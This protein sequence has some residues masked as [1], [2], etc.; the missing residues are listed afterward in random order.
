MPTEEF[1]QE[2]AMVNEQTLDDLPEAF[3]LT[4]TSPMISRC[5]EL[6]PERL[7]VQLER[8]D[9][10]ND[11]EK[12]PLDTP[13]EISKD[14]EMALKAIHGIRDCSVG[15]KE[16]R[17]I[18]K[19]ALVGSLGFSKELSTHGIVLKCVKGCGYQHVFTSYKTIRSSFHQHFK[20]MH[21]DDD[22]W[23][24]YCSACD[25]YI[26]DPDDPESVEE[27]L[28]MKSELEHIIKHHTRSDVTD[29]SINNN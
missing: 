25:S 5:E 12:L 16:M 11:N 10:L 15:V 22:S 9:Q 8:Y 17:Y 29:P 18:Y 28:T 26:H 20:Q 24:G 3:A 2:E 4:L 27:D 21:A 7:E 6:R 13:V 1:K 19:F 14:D 23:H